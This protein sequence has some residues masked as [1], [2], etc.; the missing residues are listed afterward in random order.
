MNIHGLKLTMVWLLLLVLA[1]PISLSAQY[2][3]RNK[4]IYK[5]FKFDVFQ[6]PNYEIY[7]YFK[8]DSVVQRLA[9]ASEQWYNMHYQVFGDSIK[10]RNPLIFYANHADFQQTTAIFGSV[11]VG[12][13][14]VTEALKNRVVMPV[15]ETWAQTDHV[16]GHELVHA[17]QFNAII[18]GDST[19]LNSLRNLPLWMVE[20][21]AEY[22][23]IGSVDPHT[24]MWMRDAVLNNKFPTLER[25]TRD[26][27]YFPYRYGHAF[28]AFIGR[29]FGDELIVPIFLETAKRGYDMA[30]RKYLGLNEKEFSDIWRNAN[31]EHYKMS[32]KDTIDSP[33]GKNVINKSNAGHINI[34]PS[35]SPS[36]KYI[37]FYSE[38]DLFDIDLFMADAE[39]GKI[40]QKI[41]SVVHKNEIDALNFIE[42]AGTWSPDSKLFAFVAFSKGR[43]RLL[44]ADVERRRMVNEIEIPGVPSFNY[45][46]WS[47]KG[48]EIVVS[49]LVD[50]HNDLFL[51]NLK[52]QSVSKLTNDNWCNIHP[53]WSP[54]GNTLVYVTDKP[55]DVDLFTKRMP[56]YYL[57]TINMRD[58]EIK[59]HH[60]FPGAQNLNPVYSSD[61]NEIYFLSNRDGFRN[62]YRFNPQ[63]GQVFK[64]T[65]ILT[66]ISGMTPLSPAF[67]HSPDKDLF[68]YS[69]YFDGK[70]SVFTATP[71]DFISEEVY[72][73]MVD[74][75]AGTLPPL[76][77]AVA[78]II[79]KNISKRMGQP[80]T[81]VDSFKVVRY[82]P[83]FRLDYISNAGIGISTSQMGTGMAGGVEM[84]FSDIVGGNL[85]HVGLALNGEIYD[86]GGQVT[87]I[88]QKRRVIWGTTVSHIPFSYGQYGFSSGQANING[89]WYE[90]DTISLYYLR[91]FE[92]AIGGMAQFPLSQTRRFELGASQA[93]YNYRLDVYSQVYVDGWFYNYIRREGGAQDGFNLRGFQLQRVNT[94]FVIDNSAFGIASPM[95]GTRSRLQIEKV[96]GEVNFFGTLADFRKY[97][98]A[99]PFSFAFRAYYNG[100]HGKASEMA[101]IYPLYLGYPWFIRGYDRGSTFETSMQGKTINF[102]QILGDQMIVTNFEIRIPFTGPERLTLI[103]SKMFY[104]EIAFF[105]DAG[106]AWTSDN[107]PKFKWLPDNN[108][109]KIPIVSTGVSLRVNL[110]GALIIEPYYAIPYQLGGLQSAYFG[111]NFTPG[112]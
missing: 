79:D 91:T 78:G 100:R 20:G 11:G 4:P 95:N 13:G 98:F 23:S 24:A 52:T 35:I 17:F 51:Y 34:T 53:S 38:K 96:F 33:A 110:F 69:Y 75:T 14:G 30:L 49:G 65:H 27:S 111:L 107:L 109:E 88:N 74:F 29:N 50:G 44:I 21:M 83:K 9:Q 81:P 93:W 61:G 80:E 15:T 63:T 3:G 94:A 77:R 56:G 19:N 102:N 73:M 55:S 105:A 62:V 60:I 2:F 58:R 72:P 43:N 1:S 92:T 54:D 64:E 37:A 18:S 68:A 31:I 108:T 7:H 112:W 97:Y 6:T 25:M 76:N 101:R 8:D 36:G 86:F 66:G 22:L 10:E 67:S 106:V 47:P 32:M 39:T 57:A 26:Q 28:W 70:Y 41:S 48:D 40:V 89:N 71:A 103:K 59:T 45:P 99:K 85:F 5:N 16:L 12:T 87:Y 90:V 42:S 84:L 46:A 82:R 104:S